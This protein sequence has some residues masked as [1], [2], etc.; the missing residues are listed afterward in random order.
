MSRYFI[1]RFAHAKGRYLVEREAGGYYGGQRIHDARQARYGNRP[2]P[3]TGLYLNEMYR[4]FSASE[5][6]SIRPF[7]PPARQEA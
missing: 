4:S 5:L 3:A 1:A 2:D 7:T 6:V